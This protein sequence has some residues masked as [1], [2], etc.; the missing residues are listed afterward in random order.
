MAFENSL[1][2]KATA[3]A[4]TFENLT[5][6]VNYALA[7]NDAPKSSNGCDERSPKGPAWSTKSSP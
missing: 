7:S 3:T 2:V 5:I 1:A 4:N 6:R